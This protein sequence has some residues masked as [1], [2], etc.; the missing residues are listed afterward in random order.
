MYTLLR[1]LLRLEREPEDK[2]RLVCHILDLL[3]AAF[4]R[5]YPD[6]APPL[7]KGYVA[8]LED[9]LDKARKAAED[10]GSS[11]QPQSPSEPEAK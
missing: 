9:F 7:E 1:R 6:S 5:I 11:S 10:K 4:R 2:L 8:T 3:E